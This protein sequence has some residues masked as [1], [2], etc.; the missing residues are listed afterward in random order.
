MNSLPTV[1]IVLTSFNQ[2]KQLERAFYSLL[3]QTFKDIEI[4]IVD[5]C[6]TE[7][8]TVSFIES[9]CKKYPDLVKSKIQKANVGIA[10]NKN[11]G[12]KMAS[13]KFITYL[14]GDDYYY[15]EKI[16]KELNIIG[17]DDSVDVVYSNFL[18]EDFSGNT[19][20]IW[21]EEESRVPEGNIFKEVISRSFPKETL[22]RCELIRAEV[23][24]KINYYDEEIV[25]YHDWDSRIRYSAFSKIKYV[26]NIGSVYVQDP[27]GVSKIKSQTFLSEEMNYVFE[28]NMPLLKELPVTVKQEIMKEMGIKLMKNQ[29]IHAGSWI[30]F[31]KYIISYICKKPE[32]M[33]FV[34]TQ[35]YRFIIKKFKIICRQ[36]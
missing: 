32:D 27:A 1:S 22:F 10:K 28:K 4:I 34:L 23:L 3:D 9:V 18:Y 8:E 33:E 20:C 7:V 2:K 16:E 30:T 29:L 12:F 14:D 15:P 6:S 26:N 21:K 31:F 24:K 11:T 13:G 17:N 5:D 19:I 36:N 25:A 35:V